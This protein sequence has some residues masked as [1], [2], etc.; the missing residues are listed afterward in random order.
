MSGPHLKLLLN[1][2]DGLQDTFVLS[3]LIALLA[4]THV[5]DIVAVTVLAQRPTNDSLAT[6]KGTR[7]GTDSCTPGYSDTN[8]G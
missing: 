1:K 3:R 7:N 2:I 4:T 5:G 6:V 8:L